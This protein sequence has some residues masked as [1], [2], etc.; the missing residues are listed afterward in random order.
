MSLAGRA[1]ARRD[2]RALLNHTDR[3]GTAHQP[4][5]RLQIH[6]QAGATLASRT[7]M[8]TITHSH[9]AAS[10]TRSPPR[11]AGRKLGPVNDLQ[12]PVR[13]AKGPERRQRRRA[14]G[15]EAR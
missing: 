2:L 6:L 15:G 12:P 4:A 7:L 10:P 8:A 1:E 5:L 14:G 9:G 3:L 13:G 11:T